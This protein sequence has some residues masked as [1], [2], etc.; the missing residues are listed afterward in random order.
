MTAMSAR[1]AH[2]KSDTTPPGSFVK[3]LTPPPSEQ[4]SGTSE[5]QI[6]DEIEGRKTGRGISTGPWRRYRLPQA[7]YERLEKR[8]QTDGFVQ[9]KL[10]Y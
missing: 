8:F 2:Q 6:I 3:P 4:K 5:Q 9:D 10:R 7:A 1:H